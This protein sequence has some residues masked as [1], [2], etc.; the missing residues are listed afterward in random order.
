MLIKMIYIRSDLGSSVLNMINCIS[1]LNFIS[2]FVY[3]KCARKGLA[4]NKKTSIKLAKVYKISTPLD[5][6]SGLKH[7]P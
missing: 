4:Q 1:R 3:S 5:H 7:V 2:R 6:T